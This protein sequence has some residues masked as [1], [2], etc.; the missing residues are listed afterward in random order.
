VP[1]HELKSEIS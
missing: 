1:E